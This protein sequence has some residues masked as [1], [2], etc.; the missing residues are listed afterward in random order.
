MQK[1]PPKGIKPEKGSKNKAMRK[2][3]DGF[4]KNRGSVFGKKQT[5]TGTKA[6]PPSRGKPS[7][8]KS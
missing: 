4:M 2:T 1:T 7:T 6:F 5:L 8:A 3:A